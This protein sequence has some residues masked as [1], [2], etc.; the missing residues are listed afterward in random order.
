MSLFDRW[1]RSYAVP[2]EA[3]GLF[4][5]LFA[6]HVL[7]LGMPAFG[8]VARF[9]PAFYNPPEYSLGAFFDSLPSPLFLELLTA[10]EVVASVALLFGYRTRLASLVLAVTVAVGLTFVLSFGKINHGPVLYVAILLIM[11]FSR[12]G[13]AF[14]IDA[15]RG[16]APG[17]DRG[18]LRWSNAWPVALMALVIGFGYFSGGLPKALVWLDFDLTTHG[19]RSW[20]IGRFQ[21]GYTGLA[22]PWLF[23][24]DN[25]LVWEMMDVTAVAFEV[26]FLFAILHLRLL[27]VFFVLAVV[28]HAANVFMLGIDF[29]RLA[30]LYTLFFPWTRILA[31][32]WGDRLRSAA[33]VFTSRRLFAAALA[34]AVGLAVLA[35]YLGEEQVGLLRLLLAPVLTEDQTRV[36]LIGL[37]L[38]FAA[39]VGLVFLRSLISDARAWWQ[40]RRGGGADVVPAP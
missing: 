37:H 3:L 8:W 21:R 20:L 4:R 2:T 31:G 5:I 26:G 23:S 7:V 1:V 9:P 27:R 12:W 13:D 34:G 33:G 30:F 39:F 10:V 40:T 24:N 38:V 19:T 28:F 36:V 11:A 14:S 35:V 16:G 32:P 15:L 6:G 18:L 17:R 29:T 22:G 25:A